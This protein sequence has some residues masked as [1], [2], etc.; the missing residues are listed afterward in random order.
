MLTDILFPAS[1]QVTQFSL[2]EK[3]IRLE[4][5]SVQDQISCPVCQQPA[6]RPHSHYGRTVADLPWADFMI[7]L[8]LTVRRFFCD[9]DACQRKIFTERLPDFV[10]P[11]ARCSL[12]LTSKQR[13]T[14]LKLGGEAGAGLLQKLEIPTSSDTLLRLIQTDTTQPSPTPRVLGVDD[15]AWC[16]GQRYGTILV[17]LERHCPVDLLPDR[18]ADSLAAWLQAHPGVEIISRDRANEYIEGA[19]RGAPEAVQVA[20]RWHLLGNLKEALERL[21][22][23]QQACLYA[24]AAPPDPQAEPEP[25][26]DAAPQPD[27]TSVSTLTKAEQKRQATR[28]RRLARYQAVLD[29][30][31][32]GIGVRA[33]ARQLGLGRQTVRRYLEADIFPEM[34]QRQKRASILDQYLPYLKQRWTEGCHNGNRLY[35]EI[36]K[37][38]YTGS[39]S[40]VGQWVAAQRQSD[41]KSSRPTKTTSRKKSKP[42]VQRPWSARYAVW[43]MLKEPDQ[44]AAD[45]K[46]ALTRMLETSVEVVRAYNFGQAFLRIVRQ[47]LWKALDPWLEAVAN[48]GLSPLQSLAASLQR[49]K[50]A[51]LAGLSL[52]WSN[53]QVEGQV[54]RLE[55]IKRQ[56]Y[57]RAKFELLR[58]RVLAT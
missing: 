34:A 35:R 3:M 32:Q 39:K 15:W 23:Q 27:V 24:A 57:G 47:R 9:N 13:Q 40:L 36:E 25:Q 28:Q 16:K 42:P 4:A 17:D 54:N 22:D 48:S 8:D 29:L 26:P 58:R 5:S 56:M 19:S 33:I 55:L 2:E 41:P 30:R 11:S 14:G 53:G 20:D 10:A 37:Q 44:L 21:L 6:H 50:A 52:P 1:I 46:V 7:C 43:L 49:D 51:V 45:K 12:R 38:G 31:Q 18:S